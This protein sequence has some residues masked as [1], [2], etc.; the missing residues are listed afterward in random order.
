M[1]QLNG[2]P[3]YLFTYPGVKLQHKIH[4]TVLIVQQK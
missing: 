3:D 1:T 2:E 4:Q